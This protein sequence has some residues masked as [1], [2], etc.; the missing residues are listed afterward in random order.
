[1]ATILLFL[2]ALPVGYAALVA[3]DF[4]QKIYKPTRQ[5][6]YFVVR[7]RIYIISLSAILWTAGILVHL[8]FD[9][10]SN[11]V[12]ALSG[13]LTIVFTVLGFLM[14]PY[15]LFRTVKQPSHISAADADGFL[16]ADEQVIGVTINGEAVA[17]PIRLISRPHII[18]DVIGGTPIHMT[19]CLLC[20][21]ALAFKSM[22][23]GE[24]MSLVAPLQWENNLMLYDARSQ[25]LIQQISGEI[26]YGPNAGEH[27]EQV[28]TQIMSWSAWQERFPSSK[29]FSYDRRDLIAPIVRRMLNGIKQANQEPAPYFPTIVE[30]DERLPNKREVL[31]VNANDIAKAYDVDSWKESKLLN[32][33][34][35][36][37]PLLVV[38]DSEDKVGS[39]FER[40]VGSQTLT[41]NLIN[42]VEEVRFIDVET[43]S[44]WTG[45][46]EA[47]SGPLE[48]TQLTQHPHL[49]K[50]MWYSWANF[51]PKTEVVV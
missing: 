21:S 16:E 50:T 40:N 46:G 31:G 35:N 12:I 45:E 39:V 18:E 17:Y 22:F 37:T 24:T 51:F 25:R 36:E 29:V 2:A 14:A 42:K 8:Y 1:M 34:F 9:L 47:V 49:N 7:N 38:Y 19:Y 20:N 4:S 13:G 3:G 41:F 44:H 43:G 10:T 30:L 28:A 6:V 48:G 15:I 11:W 5:Q 26:M 27:L 23:A 33:Q 32:E